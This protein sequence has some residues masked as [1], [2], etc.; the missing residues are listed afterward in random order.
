MAIATGIGSWPGSSLPRA[1]D[2]IASAL[3]TVPFLPELP[4]RSRHDGMVARSLALL[5]PG[6]GL[7]Q[8]MGDVKA[9]IPCAGG[10]PLTVSFA[11]PWTVAAWS[12]AEPDDLGHRLG[13]A[14]ADFLAEIEAELG[15]P[16]ALQLDEPM[17]ASATPTGLRAVADCL[18]HHAER[19]VVVHSCALPVPLESLVRLGVPASVDATALGSLPRGWRAGVVPTTGPVD[20]DALEARVRAFVPGPRLAELVVTPTC[21]LGLSADA[22]DRL[23]ATAELARRLSAG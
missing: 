17:L 5:S 19:D 23:R 22:A 12:G 1:L 3:G 4:A 2:E 10:D 18:S 11:G 9:W 7:E 8:L 14:T 15:R 6:E 13:E 16:L 20:V 21:G